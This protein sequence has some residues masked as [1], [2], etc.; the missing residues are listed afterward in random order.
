MSNDDYDKLLTQN[1]VFLNLREAS[2]CN[3][4]I[5][6][7]VRNTPIIINRIDAVEEVLGSKYPLF[8]DTLEELNELTTNIKLISDA[9]VY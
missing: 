4:L 1:I 3:T 8:Y 6:C 9:F 7:V 2:A 5:E